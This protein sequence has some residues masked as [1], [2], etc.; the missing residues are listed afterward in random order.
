[1]NIQQHTYPLPV[2][3]NLLKILEQEIQKSDVSGNYLTIVK[4]R[5]PGYSPD[6]GGFH[7]VEVMLSATGEIQYI[8]DFS[9]V[10]Y[11][12]ELVKEIDFDFST[13][14]TQCYDH[15]YPICQNQTLFVLWQTNFCCYYDMGIYNI[16][17]T[18]VK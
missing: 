4:F 2:S 12:A 9:Y 14:V 6:T 18:E 5:D 11:P 8:T 10:G 13:G 3:E 16:S 7:P 15:E 1:M 17:V